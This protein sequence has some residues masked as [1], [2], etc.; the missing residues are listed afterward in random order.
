VTVELEMCLI[1]ELYNCNN[2]CEADDNAASTEDE[3]GVDGS[4]SAAFDYSNNVNNAHG[5]SQ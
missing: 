5:E 3:T 2:Y 1:N 4:T